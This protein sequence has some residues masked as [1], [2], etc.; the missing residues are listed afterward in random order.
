LAKRTARV[1]GVEVRPERGKQAV[2]PA[3]AAR[4]NERDVAEQRNALRLGQERGQGV[5]TRV[6]QVESPQEA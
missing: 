4:G 1:L 6:D 5:P 3:I 2:A